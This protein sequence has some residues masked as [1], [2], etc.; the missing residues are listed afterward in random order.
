MKVIVVGNVTLRSSAGTP[1]HG[2]RFPLEIDRFVLLSRGANKE[3][4]LRNTLLATVAATALIAGT[5]AV[6][7]QG[8]PGGGGAPAERM[9][10]GGGAGAGQS[11]RQ[12]QAP[13][14]R[15]EKGTTGQSQRGEREGQA[16]SQRQEKSTIGQ[17]SP[18]GDREGQMAPSQRQERGTTGQSQREGQGGR[19]TQR[20]GQGGRETQREGQGGREMQR[21]S[22][23]GRDAQRE[24][25]GRDT[26]RQGQDTQRQGQDTQRQ[27]QDTQRQGQD[28]QRQGQDTQRGESGKQPSAQSK[29]GS[30]SGS[31]SFTNEQKT[32]IRTTVLQSG[33]APRVSRSDVNINLRVGAAVPRDRVKLVTVP[34]T[35]V[36]YHPA[37]RG[38]LYFIVDDEIVIVHPRTY[39]IVA[40]V[41][42]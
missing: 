10:R 35:I 8:T 23:G 37:W 41:A 1:A 31:V 42:V 14:Q 21:E 3:V 2:V 27:G 29:S 25:Q 19:E 4:P 13:S 40:V 38:Y 9:D 32:K 26:Q 6:S 24:G 34:T 39:E 20:E 28:T 16:P 5:V 22:Q 7:A 15:Q 11:Q 33:N 30:A 18:R 17:S 36:E 12:E